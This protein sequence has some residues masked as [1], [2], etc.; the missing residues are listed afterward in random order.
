MENQ[1]ISKNL[2]YHRKLKGYTQEELSNKTT[3]GIRTIQRIEKG[4][5]TPHLQTIKLLATALEIEVEDLLPLENPKEESIQQKWLL[6]L[7]ATPLL[8]LMIP[9][10]NI[11]VPVFLWIHKREDNKIYDIHGRAIIN[12]QITMTIL[13]VLSFI[14]LVTIEGIGFFLFITIIP[15]SI[16]VTIVNIISVLNSKKIYYPLS[17]PFLR[18]NKQLKHTAILICLVSLNIT[19]CSNGIVSEKI[20]RLDTSTITKDSITTKVKQLME[21]ANVHGMALTIYN[22]NQVTYQKTFGYKNFEKKQKL[23]D[24]TNIYGASFSKAVFSVLVMKLVEEGYLTLDTPLESYLSKKIYEY[25][26]KTRWHD[27]FSDLQA[28]SLY[29]K[30]T[31]RMCLSH[32]TGFPNYRWF[33]PD[34]KLRV[35]FNPGNR[36]QYSGEG[37][38]YLQV[39]IEKILGKG[40]EEIAQE[41]IFKPLKMEQTSYQ[42]NTSF[43]KDFAYGHSK[44]GKLFKKDKDNEPRGG[45]TLETTAEDYSKFLTAVLQQEIISENSWNEIFKPQIRIR[46]LAQFGPLSLKEGS[47]NDAIELSYGLG[48]G[49]LQSSYGIGAF[50]EGH[51]DGFQHYSIVFPEAKKGIMI[52]TNS[53]NG[54]SIFKEL[55]EVALGDTFTP[56]KWENYIPYNHKDSKN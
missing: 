36:Y 39:I 53:E 51:G 28:D 25:A 56:W 44:D 40:L 29:H 15:F 47:L 34:H 50:K 17:I 42:W 41:K 24:T 22:D 35:H 18:K 49:V 20:T 10:C 14:G 30:I 38:I 21:H 55:L 2:V 13:F 43:E 46:T 26:P 9:F 12:F 52:M 3:V 48:W 8:G 1:S 5:V 4:E 31:A 27:N 32:T 16:I 45:G 54:E 33:E 23:T 19:S 11:L 7:H 37:F 6:L